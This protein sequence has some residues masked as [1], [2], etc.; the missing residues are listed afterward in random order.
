[1]SRFTPWKKPFCCFTF[2][3]TMT[4]FCCTG[5]ALNAIEFGG[6]GGTWPKSWP[7]ELES[8]RKQASTW[9]GGVLMNTRYEIPFENREQFEAAWPHLLELKSPGTSLTLM[10][11]PRYYARSKKYSAGVMVL[12]PLKGQTKG[13]LSVTRIILMVDGKIID[14]NRIRLPKET[15]IVD[16]R[17]DEPPQKKEADQPQ[18]DNDAPAASE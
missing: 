6:P 18:S 2:A 5:G 8:L 15:P 9:Q 10:N 7:A 14:L 12:P 3:L 1:M 16:R 17:F 4:L 13:D 11:G